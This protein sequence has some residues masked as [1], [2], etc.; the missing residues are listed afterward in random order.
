MTEFVRCFAV[1]RARDWVPDAVKLRCYMF[2]AWPWETA[3]EQVLYA[4]GSETSSIEIRT[5][6][7][8]PVSLDLS[9]V[10]SAPNRIRVEFQAP[11]ELKHEDRI[12]T[13]PRFPILFSRIRDRVNTLRALYGRGPLD[14]DFKSS[15]VR[16]EAVRMTQYEFRRREV[17]RKSSRT[18]QTHTIGGFVGFAEYEGEWPSFSPIWKRADGLAWVGRRGWGQGEIAVRCF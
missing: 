17:N 9:P 8:E 12:A 18:G 3:Q 6:D 11:T 15:A 16:A 5:N 14:I 13:W 2:A 10:A 7:V 1:W 4:A